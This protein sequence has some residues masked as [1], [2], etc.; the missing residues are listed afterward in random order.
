MVDVFLNLADLT[1]RFAQSSFER[2]GVTFWSSFFFTS[3]LSFTR[4]MEM[5]RFHQPLFKR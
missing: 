4:A 5:G 1:L 3:T 2:L